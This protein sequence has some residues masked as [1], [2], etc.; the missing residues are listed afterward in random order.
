MESN[1]RSQTLRHATLVHHGRLS[2]MS[3]SYM[4]ANYQ[5]AVCNNDTQQIENSIMYELRIVSSFS[6]SMQVV[7]LYLRRSAC[8]SQFVT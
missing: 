3:Y 6:I 2:N 7:L 1:C 5:L 4:R 8:L